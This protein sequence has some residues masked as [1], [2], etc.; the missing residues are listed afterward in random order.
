MTDPLID[1]DVRRMWVALIDAGQAVATPCR[2]TD[3]DLWHADHVEDRR[4]AADLCERCPLL[5][6]CRQYADV[7]GE[8]EGVWGGHDRTTRRTN[9]KEAA[10]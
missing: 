7:A 9:R 8:T 10:A 5:D 4:T 2:S 1:L 6:P 3:P